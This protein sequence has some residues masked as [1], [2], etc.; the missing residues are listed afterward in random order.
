MAVLPRVMGIEQS[1]GRMRRG[2]SY[3]IRAVMS[4]GTTSQTS[5]RWRCKS[6]VVASSARRM[7]W[8]SSCEA[9]GRPR[10]S[11]RVIWMSTLE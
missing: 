4:T 5:M 11:T 6:A 10:A 3:A 9:C 7:Y 2:T 8:S 1:R